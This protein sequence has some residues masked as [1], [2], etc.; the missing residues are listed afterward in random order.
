M[1]QKDVVQLNRKSFMQI[2]YFLFKSVSRDLTRNLPWPVTNIKGS[3]IFLKG[4]F[5]NVEDLKK[6]YPWSNIPHFQSKNLI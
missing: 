2:V 6:E 1:L 4:V 3:E 5:K